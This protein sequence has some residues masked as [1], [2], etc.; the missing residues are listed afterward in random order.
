MNRLT[1]RT[2]A[3]LAIVTLIAS[4]TACTSQLRGEKA[5]PQGSGTA[6]PPN[7]ATTAPAPSA[8]DPLPA[9]KVVDGAID[10]AALARGPWATLPHGPDPVAD[11]RAGR[12]PSLP[13]SSGHEP[14][15]SERA[16]A[17][18]DD[19][20][21]PSRMVDPGS[22]RAAMV[23]AGFQEGYEARWG[24]GHRIA[25]ISASRYRDARAAKTVLTTHL[26]AL[27]P[28]A[29]RATVRDD[30]NG[31]TLVRDSGTVR[32]VFVLDDVEVS[33]MVCVCHGSSDADREA[34]ID[35]W[36]DGVSDVMRKGAESN[37]D[38]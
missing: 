13:G 9:D 34:L 7:T 24:T 20:R 26:L 36:S 29:V 30:R 4:L 6:A 38:A 17:S 5:W 19:Y 28:E 8:G 18:V 2:G 35:E 31:L 25:L 27:C 21:D 11:I 16:F 12:V 10:C 32:T 3:V 22:L 1:T 14:P 15:D 23:K 37:R 33:V